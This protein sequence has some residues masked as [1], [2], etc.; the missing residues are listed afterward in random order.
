MVIEGEKS[1]RDGVAIVGHEQFT[2]SAVRSPVHLKYRPSVM[3]IESNLMENHS[4]F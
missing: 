3:T 2:A 1:R 4:V